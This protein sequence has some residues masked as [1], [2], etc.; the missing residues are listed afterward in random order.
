MS[1]YRHF[2][3]FSFLPH[4]ER[5]HSLLSSSIQLH[6]TVHKNLIVHPYNL[7]THHA[8]EFVKAMLLIST[9]ILSKKAN[10]EI[11]ATHQIATAI[12]ATR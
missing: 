7:A 9:P 11:V 4:Y 5:T 8:D 1:P 3:T 12:A 6:N 2:L 10:E